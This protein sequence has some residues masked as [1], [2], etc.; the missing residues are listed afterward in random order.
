MV[1]SLHFYGIFCVTKSQEGN[2]YDKD[3]DWKII[4]W[5][6]VRHYGKCGQAVFARQK[7]SLQLRI[8]L[9]SWKCQTLI[10]VEKMKTNGDCIAE[11][12]LGDAVAFS[13]CGAIKITQSKPWG[14]ELDIDG[15]AE[16]SVWKIQRNLEVRFF[17]HGCKGNG[18]RY[19]GSYPYC[20]KV[21]LKISVI[22]ETQIPKYQNSIS[23]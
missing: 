23:R 12:A 21:R 10:S 11:K 22:D 9:E 14:I 2:I 1:I 19:A 5:W 15:Q 18:K 13:I 6:Q 8:C 4:L 17:T 7:D 3:Y 20:R 16:G